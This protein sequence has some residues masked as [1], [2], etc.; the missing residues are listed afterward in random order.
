MT[1]ISRPGEMTAARGVELSFSVATPVSAVWLAMVGSG[2]PVGHLVII[3][4]APSR[5][6]AG[7]LAFGWV[8][9]ARHFFAPTSQTVA[10]ARTLAI[11]SPKPRYRCAAAPAPLPPDPRFQ[12]RFR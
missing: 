3:Y 2:A 12:T 6:P 1:A 7:V 4:M 11:T 10:Q 5:R 8:G 9:W